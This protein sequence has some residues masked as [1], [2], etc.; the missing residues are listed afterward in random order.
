MDK[1]MEVAFEFFNHLEKNSKNNLVEIFRKF[2]EEKSINGAPYR[3]RFK[4]E[5]IKYF[6]YLYGLKETFPMFVE[7]II[8]CKKIHILNGTIFIFRD[9]DW[10]YQQGLSWTEILTRPGVRQSIKWV[11]TDGK[12]SEIDDLTNDHHGINPERALELKL[13]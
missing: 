9:L 1:K 2:S 10:L 7:W 3:Q 5:I 13:N 4:G 12:L 8:K 6:N 11:Y